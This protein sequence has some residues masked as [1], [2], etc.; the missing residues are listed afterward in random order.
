MNNKIALGLMIVI[1]LLTSSISVFPHHGTAVAY[2]G[3]KSV[4]MKGTVT[5]FVFKNPHIQLRF[6]VK[7]EKGNV[8][9]WT[10]ECGGV[11]FWSALGWR[12]DSL[13]PGDQITISVHPSRIGAPLGEL[14]V[15]EPPNGKPVPK[16]GLNAPVQ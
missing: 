6:D 16:M 9:N 4:S 7:D 13:K 8:V 15:L 3:S 12:R 2:D 10:A 5:E 1:A 14:V 11:Y